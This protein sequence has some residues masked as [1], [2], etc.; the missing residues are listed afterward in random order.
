MKIIFESISLIELEARLTT[1][2]FDRWY[3]DHEKQQGAVI[4]NKEDKR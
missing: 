3:Y 4:L 2:K 1:L